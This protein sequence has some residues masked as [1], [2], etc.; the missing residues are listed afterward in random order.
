MPSAPV[1]VNIDGFGVQE[2]MGM[3]L[4]REGVNDVRSDCTS[5]TETDRG[6]MFIVNDKGRA[7]ASRTD[8][9]E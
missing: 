3:H 5:A 2:N 1:R 9:V 7:S 6:V 4:P 8:L